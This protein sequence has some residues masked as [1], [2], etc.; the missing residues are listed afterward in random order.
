[1]IGTIVSHYRVLE[2]LGAGGM[3]VVYLA[4]DVRL[5]RKVALKFLAPGV[6]RDAT[7][8]ARLLREAQ[9]ASALD[10]PHIATVYEI[11]DWEGQLFIAMAYY[12]GETLRHRIDRGP[13]SIGEI[14]AIT[15]QIAD[16][17]ATAHAAGI[18]HR[19]LKPANIIITPAGQ[20]K[21][22][23]FGL[24]KLVS[25]AEQETAMSMTQ[26]GTTVGTVAYM[27]P[28]QARG[29]H[30]DQRADIWALGAVLYEMITGR[31]PFDGHNLTAMLLALV[32]QQPAPLRSLRPD[33]PPELE[34][35]VG[36]AL[37]KDSAARTLTAA[38]VAAEIEQYRARTSGGAT[39]VIGHARAPINRRRAVA[40]ILVAAVALA[41]AGWWLVNA[42]RHAAAEAALVDIGRLVEEQKFVSAYDLA[43]RTHQQLG[44]DPRLLA[45]WPAIIR[46]VTVR[47]TP[48][49]ADVFFSDYGRGD[50]A[51][52]RLGATPLENVQVPRGILRWKVQKAGL[53]PMEDVPL[54]FATSVNFV[55]APAQSVPPGMVRVVG[56]PRPLQF[57]VNGGELRPVR[58]PDFWIDRYE[59]T[60]RQFKA[61][62]DAS[63]YQKREHWK[64]PFVKDGRTLSWDDAMALFRDATGRP[65]PASWEL[66][67]YPAGQDDL[68]V[69]GVS[70]Y[71]AAAYAE[72]A[73]RSLPTFYHWNLVA[74]HG[75]LTSAVVPLANYSHRGPV[76]VGSTRAQHRFGAYDLAGNVK[77]WCA[78]DD[79]SGRRYVLGGGWDE[80]AY[81][82]V[83]SDAR[84]PFE[85]ARNVGFRCIRYMDGDASR[86]T[87]TA[88]VRPP[89]RD[90]AREKPVSD[91]VFQAYKRLYSYDRTPI[92][93]VVESVD[94]N[95]IDWSRETVA[96]PAPYADE[97]ITVHLFLPKRVP[98]PF[99]TVMFFPGAGAWDLRTSGPTIQ[100]PFLFDFLMKSGR[101]VALPV[102]KGAYER[103]DDR[104]RSDYPKN[105]SVWRDHVIAWY[106]DMARTLDYLETRRDLAMDKVGYIGFSRGGAVAPI[107]LS[108]EPR[109]KAAVFWVPG[110]YIERPPPEVDAINFAPRMTI[111]TLVLNGRYD[112]TF[113]EE[114]SQVPFFQALGTP[115]DQ[116]RRVVYEGGHNL[117]VNEGIKE[118]L[119]W[120]DR[121]LGV[122]R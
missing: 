19:D 20:A 8:E 98:P 45:L 76:P 117:P 48:P 115:P 33:V 61:F 34:R 36:N 42:R 77:E 79:G 59:V 64:H 56:P 78:N 27:A 121:H 70:W 96:F 23:D 72:F 58:I 41:A 105:T 46:T 7:A 17:L 65:G 67:S 29:E 69:I 74:G 94:R 71:E 25:S 16:G 22:L 2:Q 80:P 106:K 99:Q 32:T 116:K 113:P 47:S 90:Y 57:Y 50:P 92:A 55:L 10:H 49:A 95:P 84:S 35:I 110:F 75:P 6:A 51:W 104:F 85:R 118:T 112:Y 81:M 122:V 120:F 63:G 37:E 1:M 119:D 9:S 114:A 111:P 66:G 101:A 86:G 31:T 107:L 15:G 39:P 54:P 21:I 13:M 26:A 109:V 87:L 88:A 24:A 97:R 52:R 30:V 4:E 91:E 62:V 82:Y 18:I 108:Q 100:T 5:N 102:F 89:T 68:P 40:L 43:T 93:A 38:H 73:G 3:G 53:A 12:A 103:G 11:G 14:A 83:D 60:N 28:E 44:D